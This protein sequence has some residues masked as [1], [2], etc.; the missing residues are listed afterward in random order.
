MP[1]L[2]DYLAYRASAEADT[3]GELYGTENF[4]HFLYGLVRMDRPSTVVELGC[5]GGAT[6]VMIGR[7]LTENGHGHLWTVD[8]GSDWSVGSIRQTCQR[9]LGELDENESYNQFIHRLLRK[10]D[11]SGAVTLV[12][13]YLDGTRWFA[14]EN[15]RVDMLFSDAIGCSVEGC[16]STLRYYLPRISTY[17]SI[18]IDRAGTINHVWLFLRYLID[19]FNI[20][21]IPRDLIDGLD[22]DD[23]SAIERLVNGC[24]FQ[25]INLTDTRHNK[26][27]WVQNSRA[28]IKIQPV[29][30]R[31]H[32]DVISFGSI[33]R[34]WTPKNLR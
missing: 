17:S 19:Q 7:A 4:C 18:F 9:A 31:P 2:H 33:P 20:G 10:F 21:K 32:N 24:E 29:D 22:N 30:Y 25:L 28:W 15:A 14:L 23:S 16:V 11:L 13:T 1:M 27:N 12:D 34:P 6:A 5:G 3:V 26:S 8:D